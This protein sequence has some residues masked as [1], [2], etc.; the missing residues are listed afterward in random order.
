MNQPRS[1]DTIL[2]FSP[3]SADDM[4][5]RIVGLEEQFEAEH[6]AQT[7]RFEA[8]RADQRAKRDA[9]GLIRSDDRAVRALVQERRTALAARQRSRLELPAR[10]SPR[11]RIFT[12][13]LG[14][15]RVPPFWWASSWQSISGEGLGGGSGSDAGILHVYA[16][17][18]QAAGDYG[19]LGGPNSV[20]ARAWVGTFFQPPTS[21]GLLTVSANPLVVF[22]YGD[23]CFMDGCSTFGWIGLFVQEYDRHGVPSGAPVQQQNYLWSDASWWS[24][25]GDN[26][27]GT[28]VPLSTVIP[29]D[30]EHSYGLF[31]WCGVTGNQ[32]GFG[33]YYYS[34]GWG[35][36]N[37][38]VPWI[39]WHLY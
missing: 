20:S 4:A 24:G 6:Q 19:Y 15:T 21:E 23:T 7:A 14:A 37:V 2:G 9:L 32:V 10:Q 13:S 16:N 27:G 31:V 3:P 33:D 11:E 35:E 1:I 34:L 18:D 28:V 22:D 5:R 29:V 36:M 26:S 38:I 8:L 12:G 30:D 25:I 39:T 17:E